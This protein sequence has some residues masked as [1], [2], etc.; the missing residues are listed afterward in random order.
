MRAMLVTLTLVAVLGALGAAPAS[1]SANW[2]TN[3]SATGT[4]FT[5]TAGSASWTF[6]PPG[7]VSQRYSCSNSSA[8]G[9]LFGSSSSGT[10]LM[11][12]L[13]A[14]NGFCAVAGMPFGFKCEVMPFNGASY[15]PGTSVTTGTMAS[16]VCLMAKGACGNT[17]TY[18]ATGP[19][20]PIVISGQVGATY[21]NTSQ[22]LT[23]PLTG[24][25]LNARWQSPGC[26]QG[27]GTGATTVT[28]TSGTGTALTFAAT[29]TFRPQITN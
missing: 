5:M 20:S 28:L 3:G 15:A 29:G 2:T 19:N 14:F 9:A 4:A 22:Q 12:W 27:T 26:I 24:Q 7:T 10:R 21:G 1:A 6:H 23:I 11:D 18:N 13:P 8:T 25:A 17:T 16:F